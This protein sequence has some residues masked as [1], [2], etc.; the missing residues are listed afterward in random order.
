V[1]LLEDATLEGDTLVVNIH[2]DATW[3]PSDD[4]VT[5]E[6]L[7]AHYT[8]WRYVDGW[9]EFMDSTEIVD[10]KTLQINLS[11]EINPSIALQQM[12]ATQM[13]TKASIFEDFLERL[14]GLDPESEKA[15]SIRDE[16]VGTEDEGGFQID[17]EDAQ[18]TGPFTPE[19]L[20]SDD[21]TGVRNPDYHRAENI[22]FERTRGHYFGETQKLW[23][24]LKTGGDIDITTNAK[25][26]PEITNTFPDS[27]KEVRWSNY[28]GVAIRFQHR[29][30]I[31]RKLNVRKA[32][33]WAI[34]RDSIRN[35]VRPDK[36]VTVKK[37]YILQETQRGD[38]WMSD[39]VA[40]NSEGY[41]MAESNFEKAAELLKSEGF[42]KEDG[43]WYKPDGS[44][45]QVTLHT[46]TVSD[47]NLTGE[48]A[49]GQ[50]S[51]F[52]IDIELKS[53]SQSSYWGS[54]FLGGEWDQMEITW[55]GGWT[56]AHPYWGYY[57]GH[58]S[59]WEHPARNYPKP[60]GSED[61]WIVE[62]PRPVGDPNGDL[63]AVNIR[64]LMSDL[65]T[66][67]DEER[68]RELR[69]R[70]QRFETLAAGE[71]FEHTFETAGEYRYV[72]VPHAGV[73]MQGT[74][75]VEG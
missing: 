65:E 30:E 58:V 42:S 55:S 23:Q 6:D 19:E 4:P 50:L 49:V 5:A 1:G 44:P 10:E 20:R 35:T 40:G 56:N 7:D 13:Q 34:N 72:C 57:N 41:G 63:E 38:Y 28:S 36:G 66:T 62:S 18:F 60:P 59:P 70:K 39:E 9:P 17:L 52:G 73:G 11:K 37:P 47:W 74:V 31:F 67:Q 26:S 16:L 64:D 3:K 24:N 29:N 46:N 45:W 54:V 12:I 21:L 51:E 2:P 48:L 14:D 25:A 68:E 75:V 8:L 53:V 71:T 27:I 43:T 69:R 15:K 33:A 61:E 22:T 32:I